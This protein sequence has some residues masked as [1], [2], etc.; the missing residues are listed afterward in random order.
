MRA[1]AFKPRSSPY[2]SR[3]WDRK[4]STSWRAPASSTGIGIV[5]ELMDTDNADAVE[6][7]ADVIQIGARNMQN[8]SLLKRVSRASQAGAAQARPVGDAG[9]MADGRR[10]CHGRRQLQRRSVRARRPHLLRS[11]PQY[12]R[13]VGHSAGQA[14]VA[15]ADSGR[16]QPRHRQ[17]RLR[18]GDGPG[19]PGRRRRRPARSRSIP[20]RIARCPMG[21]S[22]WTSPASRDC[23]NRCAGW[24]S[25]SAALSIEDK[26]T[27]RARSHKR[28]K[29]RRE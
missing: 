26:T 25:R 4:D 2:A 15:P 24:P 16:S 11:Q 10:V 13:P 23:W 29:P 1:G 8:F 19:R 14:P 7:A 18:A 20:T 27:R 6:E 21:R 17:A 9:R 5:T 28:K 22:R 3:A 12:A